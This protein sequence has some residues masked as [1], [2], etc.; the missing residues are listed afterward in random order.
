[1]PKVT[2]HSNRRRQPVTVHLGGEEKAA[3]S[4]CAHTADNTSSAILK[5]PNNPSVL[6]RS[7]ALAVQDADVHGVRGDGK[8]EVQRVRQRLLLLHKPPGDQRHALRKYIIEQINEIDKQIEQLLL[9]KKHWP[10][11]K[12]ACAPC[13]TLKSEV[14]QRD[15]IDLFGR[16]IWTS[17][18]L[19]NSNILA[20]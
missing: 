7:D 4:I 10:T 14:S 12:P 3:I 20:N 15:I 5:Q 19:A 13:K 11:H 6:E 9:K 2:E 18:N 1:M 8:P 16:S 17:S